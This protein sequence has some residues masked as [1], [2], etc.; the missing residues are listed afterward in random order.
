[1]KALK[2]VL[3]EKHIGAVLVG[4]I[5]AQAVNHLV[6]LVLTPVTN[7][8]VRWVRDVDRVSLPPIFSPAELIVGFVR[9]ALFLGAGLLILKWLYLERQDSQ[10][11]EAL[12]SEM[13]E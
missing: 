1:M 5:L 11:S 3:V 12:E 2:A 8:A 13:S 4:F 10:P 7:G 6:T 9:T